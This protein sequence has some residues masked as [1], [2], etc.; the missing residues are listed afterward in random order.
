MIASIKSIKWERIIHN[1]LKGISSSAI[2]FLAAV[3]MAEASK[4]L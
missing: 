3:K 4:T 2:S 1:I